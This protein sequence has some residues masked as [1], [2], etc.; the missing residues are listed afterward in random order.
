[1][2]KW[3]CVAFY[4][5]VATS[6]TLTAIT[7][8]SDP[9]FH[10][11][12]NDLFLRSPF[13]EIWLAY[14][15]F[16][17]ATRC[18]VRSPSFQNLH[19]NIPFST[20]Y[21]YYRNYL[22]PQNAYGFISSPIVLPDGEKINIYVAGNDGGV[23]QDYY[24][25][26]WLGDIPF[27]EADWDYILRCTGTIANAKQWDEVILTPDVDLPEGQY[28]LMGLGVAPCLV[29]RIIHPSSGDHRPAVLGYKSEEQ[30]VTQ[31]VMFVDF[32]T[33]FRP[34]QLPKLEVF[35]EATGGLVAYLYVKKVG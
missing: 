31:N 9:Q 32:E 4:K 23:A 28:K 35:A 13:N 15:Y 18:Q 25:F 19:L 22:F 10:T 26:V 29:A 27:I 24:A 34:T 17:N 14:G 12:G 11:S 3:T 2:A 16:A 30:L 20:N 6:N 7:P 21:D 5:N 1:M 8:V 33:V